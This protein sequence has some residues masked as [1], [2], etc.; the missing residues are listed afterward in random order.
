MYFLQHYHSIKRY[1]KTCKYITWFINLLIFGLILL[2]IYTILMKL[3]VYTCYQEARLLGHDLDIIVLT[4]EGC[5]TIIKDKF[6]P[7]KDL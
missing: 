2:S 6:I 7:L 1:L 5:G 3:P 4:K